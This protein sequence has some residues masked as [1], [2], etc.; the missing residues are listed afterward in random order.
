MLKPVSDPVSFESR[1]NPDP[2]LNHKTWFIWQNLGKN[3]TKNQRIGIFYTSRKDVH[4]LG[5]RR[6]LQSSSNKVF[7]CFC[8][9]FWD[10]FDLLGFGSRSTDPIESWSILD[11]DLKHFLLQTSNL[12]CN[13]VA[14]KFFLVCSHLSKNVLYQMINNSPTFKGVHKP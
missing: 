13:F 7:L 11:P 9:I 6:R 2:D 5:S 4:F 14:L 1:A 3:L 8:P 12:P 10:L